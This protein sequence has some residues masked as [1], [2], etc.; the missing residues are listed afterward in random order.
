MKVAQSP[1]KSP[2]SPWSAS[3]CVCVCVGT[4]NLFICLLYGCQC[5]GIVLPA[6]SRLKVASFPPLI[7]AG[8]KKFPPAAFCGLFNVSCGCQI[9][10]L[11]AKIILQRRRSQLKVLQEMDECKG[12]SYE[13]ATKAKGAK[14][15]LAQR[16]CG[17][18][19]D[20]FEA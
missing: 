18:T 19:F 5:P 16:V 13:T 15:K 8:D 17:Q 12:I 3:C 14:P 1:W 11:F 4:I 7:C 9:C 2:G 10:A 6:T 20:S